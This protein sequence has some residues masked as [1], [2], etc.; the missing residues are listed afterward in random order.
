MWIY[1]FNEIT[2]WLYTR[3]YQNGFFFFD[4]WSAVHCWNGFFLYFLF[5]RFSNYN[6]LFW[7]VLIVLLLYEIAEIFTIYIALHIFRPE[8]IKDQFTDIFIGLT[9]TALAFFLDKGI[10]K[11]YMNARTYNTLIAAIA[12]GTYSFLWVGF[13]GYQYNHG[14]TILNTPGLNTGAF[15][16]WWAGAW[17]TIE[18]YKMLKVKN[19]LLHWLLTWLG[20]LAVLFTVEYIAYHLVGIHEI[21]RNGEN[22]LI[23]NII[24][25]TPLLHFVYMI[26]PF[27]SVGLYLAMKSLIKSA[28]KKK[29]PASVINP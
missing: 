9:G 18:F 12:G 15:L 5:A 2:A 29:I 23:F 13:Y 28:T 25:G 1:E 10:R 14:F 26:S 3:I 17:G 8:T 22:P 24:H 11:S 19:I 20:Y 7:P 27:L 4:L 21:S 6:K 16:F